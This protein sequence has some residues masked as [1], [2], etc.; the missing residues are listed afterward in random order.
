VPDR[1]PD[2]NTG[3]ARGR[4][5]GVVAVTAGL[6]LLLVPAAGANHNSFSYVSAGARK[7][8]GPFSAFFRGAS[9]DG[10][11]VFFWT[12][13]QL[14]NDDTDYTWDV[15]QRSTGVTTLIS[16]GQI[17]GNGDFTA[18]FRAAS[19]DGS[20]V[21]FETEEKLTSDDADS[22]NDLYERAGG[23]TTRVS[24]G[25]ING[26]GG[27]P[28]DFGGISTDGSVV[29][30]NTGERLTSDDSDSQL[31]P[32]KR[33]GGVTE[34]LSR[35][36][37][38]GNGAFFA[39]FAGASADGSR[40]FFQSDESLA[41]ADGDASPDIYQRASGSTTLVSQ[42]PVFGAGS[43][44]QF[45]AASVDGTHVFFYTDDQLTM[46]DSDNSLIDIYER[47]AGTTTLVTE[48]TDSETFEPNFAAVSADGTRAFF[49][50]EEAITDD[51]D[52]FNDVFERS[53]G[54]V[55]RVSQGEP[56]TDDTVTPSDFCGISVD[57]TRVFFATGDAL[58]SDDTNGRYDVYQRA[59]GVT[60]GISTS[61]TEPAGP[62]FSYCG[63]SSADGSHVFFVTNVQL[64]ADDTD[65][66]NDIYE[67]FAGT[68]KL[69]SKGNGDFHASFNGASASGDKVFFTSLEPV[70]SD[71]TDA[72]EDIYQRSGSTTSRLSDGD[73]KGNGPFA[74]TVV[75]SSLDGGRLFFTSSEQLTSDDT[76]SSFDLFQRSGTTTTRLSAGAINGQGPQN[77]TFRGASGDGTRVFFTT[78]EPL[79]MDDSDGVVDIYRRSGGTTTLVSPGEINGFLND[80]MFAGVS[81]D[82]GTVFFTSPEQLTFDDF[83]LQVDIFQWQGGLT[84]RVSQGP[85]GGNEP[86]DATF[87][88]ASSN[89]TKVFF[90]T[91]EKL[92]SDD[93]DSAVDVYQWSAGVTTRISEGLSGGNGGS[94]ATFAGSS[95]DG[96]K[97]FF[98]TAEKLTY[99]D[100]DNVADLYQRS[101]TTTVRISQGPGTGNAAFPAGFAGTAGTHVFFTTAEPLTGDDTD[102]QVDIYDRA[103]TTTTRVSQGAI[104]G[105][106]AFAPTFARASSDG[107]GVFFTTAEQLTS[108]DSDSVVDVY[109]RSGGMTTR[110]SQGQVSGNGAFPVTFRAISADGSRLFFT[111]DEIL[112]SDDT[113]AKAD[114]YERFGGTTYRISR[115]EAPGNGPLAATFRAA[116]SDGKRVFFDTA[117]QLAAVD[118]DGSTDIYAAGAP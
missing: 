48:E 76:D 95:A 34:R 69:I 106:G 111:S 60:T 89:G 103:G 72:V 105:N 66:R 38:G 63:G 54:V 16:K 31:D 100:L 19:A 85:A 58:T 33:A 17:N 99:D 87:R 118:R 65:A 93:T 20:R 49:T 42:G 97:V 32:Y 14:T 84:R 18:N 78:S 102:A 117:E 96:G 82:G 39:V 86:I 79:T 46:N 59:F 27:F 116:S 41:V 44:A 70:T 75:G 56:G 15:Y 107:A 112:T 73:P 61:P 40:A 104:N 51:G 64:T 22:K 45:A 108:D 13:E 30:F 68:T 83:D 101:G 67:R 3:W 37:I 115:G 11:R 1:G 114:V 94:D 25:Q 47:A 74:A 55:T 71:D 12:Q 23:V 57:G 10:T 35:S 62:G 90:S 81:A 4:A 77:V 8:G 88:G 28:A 7:G 9:A 110:M 29:F 52:A 43:V 5:L 53:G 109:R 24:K 36:S 21:F 113:D 91:T 2:V 6:V 98:T 92:I 80:V 26:N 50:T